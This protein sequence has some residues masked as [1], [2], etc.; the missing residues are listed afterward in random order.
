MQRNRNESQEVNSYMIFDKD[1]KTS[2]WG[3]NS[4]ANGAGTSEYTKV[5]IHSKRI[6]GFNI[7][8]KTIKLLEVNRSKSS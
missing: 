5:K 4:L 6:T 3:K 2:Q 7:T 1:T 8:A